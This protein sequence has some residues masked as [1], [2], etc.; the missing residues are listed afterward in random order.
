MTF[1]Q[2]ISDVWKSEILKWITLITLGV[3]KGVFIMSMIH[4]KQ[5]FSSKVSLDQNTH[6]LIEL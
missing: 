6:I 5:L 4:L 1:F 3:F 2:N